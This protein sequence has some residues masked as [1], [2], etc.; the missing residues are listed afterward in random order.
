MISSTKNNYDA[1]KILIFDL[2]IGNF[3]RNKGNLMVDSVTKK[4]I[5]IDHTH[6]FDIGAIWD[7]YQLPR[8]IK[9]K[10]DISKL[11]QFNYNNIIGSIRFDKDF[12]N[13]LN[14][15]INKVKNININYI[16]NVIDRIPVDW[17]VTIKEKELLVKYIYERFNRIDEILDILNIKGGVHNE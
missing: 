16:K 5:M 2:L 11:H 4:L 6:I 3:D 7:E 15:F 8:S 1:I 14:I 13:E 10:F 12:Y 17:E 9:E